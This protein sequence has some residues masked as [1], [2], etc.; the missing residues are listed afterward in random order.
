[1]ITAPRRALRRLTSGATAAVFVITLA[2][3]GL[4]FSS[5]PAYADQALDDRVRCYQLL[6]SGSAG[7]KLAAQEAL[8]SESPEII[9]EFLRY[10]QYLAAAHAAEAAEIGG[11]AEQAE[12]ASRKA[13]TQKAAALA[14]LAQASDPNDSA[15]AGRARSAAQAAR[16]AA[17]AAA[18]AVE[19]AR[20]TERIARLA[21]S[22]RLVAEREFGQ[23]PAPIA[24]QL[25]DARLAAEAQER[26]DSPAPAPDEQQIAVDR[27]RV[28]QYLATGTPHVSSS[29]AKVLAADDP[30]VAR[31]FLEVGVLRGVPESGAIG[32]VI[33][34]GSA[35]S[36]LVE[37]KE[38][39]AATIKCR[40]LLP[41]S[42]YG[43]RD[44]LQ[45]RG[46]Q[47]G[48]LRHRERG[49]ARAHH[50]VRCCA[51]EAGRCGLSW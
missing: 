37:P 35:V 7:V 41:S 40:C 23:T 5:A 42:D 1:M 51:G 26:L 21:D 32:R 43:K 17:D 18:A 34:A 49:G 44:G 46:L 45:Y 22:T 9:R 28:Y 4:A 29:A 30:L 20:K 31:E 13:G 47:P 11:L 50:G 10:G 2:T 27:Q 12:S 16:E 14:A 24:K 36:A 39:G 15:A 25:E 38:V 3:A 6:A 48:G 8:G 19:A 33:R